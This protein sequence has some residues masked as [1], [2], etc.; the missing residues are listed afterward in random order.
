VLRFHQ[1]NTAEAARLLLV[2]YSAYRTD[3]WPKS[4]VQLRG[5]NLARE[6]VLARP[7]SADALIDALRTGPFPGYLMET[8]RRELLVALELNRWRNGAQPTAYG[9]AALEP[10]GRWT[11]DYL[12]NRYAFYSQT[13]LGDAT[14]ARRELEQFLAADTI[15]FD[16]G[17]KEPASPQIVSSE[18]TTVPAW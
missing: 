10:W 8:A 1:G 2:A 6:V 17:L 5:F 14:R 4:R 15:P 3:P 16:R 11:R 12:Q 13:G 7:D 9:Y 18:P